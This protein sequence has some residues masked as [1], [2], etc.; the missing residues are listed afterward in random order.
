MTEKQYTVGYFDEPTDIDS[1]VEYDGNYMGTDEVVDRLN[2]LTAKIA[3][4]KKAVTCLREKKHSIMYSN[5]K[6]RE[7]LEKE[8]QRLKQ[9]NKKLQCINNQ[10]EKKYEEKGF[11]LAYNMEE[12][13]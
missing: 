11:S 12:C 10:L 4:Y 2:G 6:A 1:Y 8:N 5:A 7:R 13:E 3:V 9:E